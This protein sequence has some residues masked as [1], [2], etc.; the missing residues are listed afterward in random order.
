MGS[1]RQFQSG[2]SKY[3]PSLKSSHS[4][5][6]ISLYESGSKTFRDLVNRNKPQAPLSSRITT[7]KLKD[8]MKK[9]SASYRKIQGIQ[10]SLIKLEASGKKNEN[11][12]TIE[13][14]SQSKRVLDFDK[15]LEQIQSRSRS[16]SD[17]LDDPETEKSRAQ[18]KDV[19]PNRSEIAKSIMLEMSDNIKRVQLRKQNKSF[20]HPLLKKIQHPASK[21]SVKSQK[22]SIQ[23]Q[24]RSTNQTLFSILLSKR[25]NR[26]FEESQSREYLSSRR[27]SRHNT[28]RK[29]NL[30]KD[31]SRN[32][33]RLKMLQKSS[34][35]FRLL[36]VKSR[37]RSAK[38]RNNFSSIIYKT[39]N[40]K[41][42]FKA[43]KTLNKLSTQYTQ[44]MNDKFS[45]SKN[46]YRAPPHLEY[47]QRSFDF[48]SSPNPNLKSKSYQQ[49][50]ISDFSHTKFSI[51][52]R[53]KNKKQREGSLSRAKKLLEKGSRTHRVLN[54]KEST[55]QKPTKTDTK[56][57]IRS[58]SKKSKINPKQSQGHST[59][60]S[61]KVGNKDLFQTANN[62]SSNHNDSSL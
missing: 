17:Y 31:N 62:S 32:S 37:S 42:S 16:L 19:K 46:S 15:A 57:A 60:P 43:H 29:F 8:S 14:G 23:E 36:K 45:L 35:Q 40:S 24:S 28:N 25:K 59:N 22:P 49:R 51:L 18:S 44:R 5:K 2:N 53:K 61:L 26:N 30:L 54:L 50:K 34:S 21:N 52:A 7:R 11:G 6:Q 41:P 56:I 20:V 38:S 4:K 47:F 1:S 55:K 13:G 48:V 9:L 33:L 58:K 10:S 39:M 27:S 3:I 12:G